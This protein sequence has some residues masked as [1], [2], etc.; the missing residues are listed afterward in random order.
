MPVA[1]EYA[2]LVYAARLPLRG[3][4]YGR[5]SIDE[6]GNS[7]AVDAQIGTGMDLCREFNISVAGVFE[8]PGIS[9]SRYGKKTRP[10]FEALLV[11]IRERKGSIVIAFEANRYYRDLEQYIRLRKACMEADV[12]LCYNRTVYDLSKKEDRRQTA[13]D[14]IVAEEEVDN[15]HDRSVRTLLD[16]AKKG[17]PVGKILFGFKRQY[18]PDTGELLGQVVHEEQAKIARKCWEAVDAGQTTHAVA[19]WLNS[20]GLEAQR[21]S[22]APWKAETVQRM[23]LNVQYISKRVYHGQVFGDGNWPPL[24]EGEEGIALF[25]RV[26]AKLK[27]P[28]R[29]T[30]KDSAVAHLL[31]R[32]PLCG[33][34]GDHAILSWQSHKTHPYLKCAIA[35]DTNIRE[36]TLNAYAETALLTWLSAPE[37][38]DAFIPPEEETNRQLTKARTKLAAFTRQLEDAQDLAGEIDDETGEFRLSSTALAALEKKLKPEIRKLEKE[39]EDATAGVPQ[40]VRDLVLAP[41]PWVVW[42]G[43]DE[44]GLPG[45]TLEQKRFV[46]RQCVTIRVYKAPKGRPRTFD[47]SRIKLSFRGD[48]EYRE[49]AITPMQYARQQQEAAV[50]ELAAAVEKRAAARAKR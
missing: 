44:M 6:F 16:L 28:G 13:Q 32:I 34:C 14:A 3:L 7:S 43:D 27:D 20:L 12:L 33:E 37:A 41:D 15:I 45:L 36:E 1:L 31:S 17:K 21:T 19:K 47:P 46:I 11:A 2:H 4:L 18:D 49:N 10:D 23:L 40:A 8:D 30:M 26:A 48:P 29:K 35:H 38:R 5:N 25:N 50:T 9:A 39:I 22:G 42:V 24:L